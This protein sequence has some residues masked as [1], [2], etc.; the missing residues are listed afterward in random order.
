[1]EMNKCQTNQKWQADSI[2]SSLER[3][4]DKGLKNLELIN[5]SFHRLRIFNRKYHNQTKIQRYIY[6]KKH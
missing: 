3:K 2:P 1:M 4:L 5:L 6:T